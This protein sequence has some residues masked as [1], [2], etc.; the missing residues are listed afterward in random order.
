MLEAVMPD[1]IR[2]CILPLSAWSWIVIHEAFEAGLG[3]KS[4][5]N[6]LSLVALSPYHVLSRLV[7]NFL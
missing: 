4:K 6:S 3:T 1:R 2:P 7:R 5:A